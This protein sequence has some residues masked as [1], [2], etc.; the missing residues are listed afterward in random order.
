MYVR[1]LVFLKITLQLILQ[2][3]KIT[4]RKQKTYYISYTELT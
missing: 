2:R 4:P 1:I 3:L